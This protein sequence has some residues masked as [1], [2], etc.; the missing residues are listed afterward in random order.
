[1]WRVLR[2]AGRPWP[3]LSE[4]AVTDFKVAEAVYVKVKHEEA[5]AHKK[6]MREDWKK[7][8]EDLR[9]RVET[10]GGSVADVRA[11]A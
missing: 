10:S 5:D 11:V 3:V 1:M 6:Q 8:T 2:E 4:D 9:T 7:R